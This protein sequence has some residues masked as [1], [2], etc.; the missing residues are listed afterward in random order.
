[1]GAAVTGL[2]IWSASVVAYC[3]L[4]T[5]ATM[6]SVA[7]QDVLLLALP[8]AQV[9]VVVCALRAGP[10]LQP[11]LRIALGGVAA[12]VFGGLYQIYFADIIV[13]TLHIWDR[14]EGN[15][16]PMRSLI[17]FLVLLGVFGALIAAALFGA[18]RKVQT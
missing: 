7:V 9:A 4:Q 12:W 10:P 15:L 2:L 17:D 3:L 14:H 16:Q 5:L 8:L 6:I 1:M 11:P 18:R 13:G